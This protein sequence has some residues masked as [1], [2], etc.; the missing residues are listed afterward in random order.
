MDF[1]KL[2]QSLK[3]QSW[4]IVDEWMAGVLSDKETGAARDLSPYE[5]SDQVSI[6]ILGVSRF[7]LKP[8]SAASEKFC[9][10]FDR[11]ARFHG[12]GRLKQGYGLAEVI[13]EH[14]VLRDVIVRRLSAQS[15]GQAIDVEVLRRVNLALDRQFLATLHTYFDEST[16]DLRQ[17][18]LRDSLT[19][20]YNQ[21][22]FY[23]RLHEEVRRAKRYKHRFT[24]LMIDLDHFK[25]YNDLLGH[26][27]GDRLLR[28]FSNFLLHAGRQ[29][30]FV[31]RYGGDEFAIILPETEEREATE[32]AERLREVFLSAGQFKTS[33]ARLT[34]S[35]GVVCFDH[36]ATVEQLCN[37][38]DRAM[39]HS[40][41][42]G[43]NQT[44]VYCGG[45]LRSAPQ[46]PTIG[47]TLGETQP[48]GA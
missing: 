41:R 5:L 19:G 3:E 14:F 23:E 7:L 16:A 30:D 34:L 24:L 4:D 43:G 1:R 15:S 35:I 32:V 22:A 36:V 46:A 26:L 27:A 40:K 17:R 9:K 10:V 29:T 20:T 25:P 37:A 11:H 8:E 45:K 18:A 21:S 42:R 44:S 13:H 12:E 31:A 48:K 33:V 39:Y 6:L 47:G 28:T 2:S 38:A